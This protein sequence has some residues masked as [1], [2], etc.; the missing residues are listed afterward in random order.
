[1]QSIEASNLRRSAAYYGLAIVTLLNFL[2]YIDRWILAAVAPRVKSELALSDFEL[3]L[4][5]NAFLITYFVTS[6]VF[7]V[8]GDR[9]SR[10]RLMTAGVGAWSAATKRATSSPYP[11]S[12]SASQAATVA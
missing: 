10:T 5:A 9:I 8:L 2:N 1:M 4:L 7:G 12:R 11:A 6:P 3:G